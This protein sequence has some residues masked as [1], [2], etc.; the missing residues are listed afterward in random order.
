MKYAVIVRSKEARSEIIGNPIV[1]RAGERFWV[2]KDSDGWV[3][4]STSV[5]GYP[6]HVPD[7][8][9][10][11]ETASDASAFARLWKGHPWWVVPDGTFEIVEVEPVYRKVLAGFKRKNDVNLS[12]I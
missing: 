3:A 4:T 12:A 7:N 8:A 6:D 2:V 5:G 11:F 10:L 9:L 1:T